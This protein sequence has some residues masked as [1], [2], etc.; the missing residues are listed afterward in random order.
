M[1]A[2]FCSL[3]TFLSLDPCVEQIQKRKLSP[4]VVI[5]TTTT[6]PT[7]VDKKLKSTKEIAKDLESSGES[8]L[9]FCT[10][11]YSDLNGESILDVV[12]TTKVVDNKNYLFE[13]VID[14]SLDSSFSKIQ[15]FSTKNSILP[16]EIFLVRNSFGSSIGL[17]YKKENN[18]LKIRN[19]K[20]IHQNISST[21]CT[22]QY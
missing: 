10:F 18:G 12:Y 5:T 8:I 17:A 9:Y 7:Q 3:L 15:K 20:S 19:F 1:K 22:S 14:L 13:R 21:F 6:E 16:E 2:L 4:K 11:D